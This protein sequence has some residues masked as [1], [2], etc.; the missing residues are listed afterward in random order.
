[1][2]HDPL[3]TREPGGTDLG[4]VLRKVLLD[5]D[6]TAMNVLT[7]LMLFA[8]DRAQ[9]VAEV[10]QPAIEAGRIILCD[11]FSDATCAYQGFGRGIPLETINNVD[12]AARAGVNPDMTVLLDIPAEIGLARVTARNSQ[13]SEM[14]ESRIDEE[15]IAFHHIVREGY[16][17]LAQREPGRFLVLDGCLSPPEL[18][19]AVIKELVERFEYVF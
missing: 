4:L 17:L 1:M 9:H 13:V 16:L 3:L 18:A 15:E 7:E 8:A 19:D 2:G 5:P 12:E 14:S 6:T 10:I 11:R